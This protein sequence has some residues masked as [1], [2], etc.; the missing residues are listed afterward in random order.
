M[1]QAKKAFND[2][3]GRDKARAEG[4]TNWF[5]FRGETTMRLAANE[6]ESAELLA[7]IEELE[8]KV[9][10][11]RTVAL[12]DVGDRDQEGPLTRPLRQL[13]AVIKADCEAEEEARRR[14]RRVAE[15]A[16]AARESLE[17]P[18][19]DSERRW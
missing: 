16:R 1:A 12:I 2:L 19:S 14:V 11:R 8:E 15:G 3:S 7:R 9:S 10:E 6:R 5:R 4:D 17:D 13:S 18:A